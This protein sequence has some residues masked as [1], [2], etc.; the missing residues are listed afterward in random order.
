MTLVLCAVTGCSTPQQPQTRQPQERL[1][2]SA[3]G[4][5]FLITGGGDLKPARLAN[6]YL[7]S[8]GA[9]SSQ[10][11]LRSKETVVQRDC[12]TLN[13]A[14]E[15]GPNSS[16]AVRIVLRHYLTHMSELEVL[17][18]SSV[19]RSNGFAVQ[20]DEEGQFSFGTVPPGSYVIAAFGRAGANLG[21]WKQPLDLASGQHAEIK[22][23]SP[24]TACVVL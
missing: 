8:V 18:R 9:F 4:R 23:P 21:Y 22:L 13:D 24:E 12:Q 1:L 7:L 5:I 16:Q 14:R 19:G 17:F 2:A 10:D 15:L 20:A 3:K 6:V 11:A